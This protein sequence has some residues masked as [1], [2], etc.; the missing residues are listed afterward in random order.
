MKILYFSNMKHLLYPTICIFL[1]PIYSWIYLKIVLLTIQSKQYDTYALRN[2]NKPRVRF[3]AFNQ[4]A[5]SNEYSDHE[6][7]AI[8]CVA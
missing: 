4:L 2:W 3:Q 6:E 1:H 5:I 7:I 8:F